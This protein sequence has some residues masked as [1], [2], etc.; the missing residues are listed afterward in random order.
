MT[1]LLAAATTSR[2]CAMSEQ[3]LRAAV[4]Q[5]GPASHLAA[6]PGRPPPSPAPARLHSPSIPSVA[7]P[8]HYVPNS[9]PQGLQ[10]GKHPSHSSSGRRLYTRHRLYCTHSGRMLGGD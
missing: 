10:P 7:G 9:C 6:I 2:N 8:A 3:G 4:R 5:P 1:T